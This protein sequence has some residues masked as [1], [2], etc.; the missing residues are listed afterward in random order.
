[1]NKS[2]KNY[3]NYQYEVFKFMCDDALYIGRHILIDSNSILCDESIDT[4]S[5]DNLKLQRIRK[6]I[7]LIVSILEKIY[8]I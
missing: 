4:L 5:Y 6:K 3:I 8:F 1:M 2:L 7:K